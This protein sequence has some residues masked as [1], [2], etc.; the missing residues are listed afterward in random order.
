[1]ATKIILPAA[2]EALTEATIVQW[3]KKEGDPVEE[4]E[5]LFEVETDKATME[6]EATASGVLRKI[7]VPEGETI[8]ILS[9]IGI[10]ADPD[11]P[12]EA[13]EGVPA[14]KT[15]Q[16]PTKVKPEPATRAAEPKAP[17]LAAGAR[18]KASP[19][20]KRLAQEKGIDLS[21]IQGTGPDGRIE[22]ADVLAFAPSSP[23]AELSL[24]EADRVPLS[25][26]RQR[27]ARRVQQSK[28]TIPH[29]YVTVKVE[30][31][32]VQEMRGRI[33]T[34]EGRKISFNDFIL[35]ACAVALRKPE[36]RDLNCRLDGND[37]V[38]SEHINLGMV[39]ST[40]DGLLIA[41][42][43]QTDE[44]DLKTLSAEAVAAVESARQGKVSGSA[45]STFTISN[46]GMFDIEQFVA[47]INPPESAI[48]AIGSIAEEAVVREGQ[49]VVTPV[50]R[51]TLSADHRILDGVLVARFLNTV[52]ELLEDPE[53]LVS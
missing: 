35:R 38:Y 29:F 13:V 30:M 4:G 31:A 5:P 43:P 8:P 20:A 3:L 17:Q 12:L 6:V 52:K 25:K 19:V 22:K 27:I 15:E 11:E 40:E 46:L 16:E 26:I 14:A 42:V 18:I 44:K 2:G 7:L 53:Q 45:R 28:Q 34:D 51:M 48:L 21:L 47:I 39:V 1:M 41:V 36:Y 23:G 24:P 37:L 50:M 33:K 49:V 32:R 10:I 9:I